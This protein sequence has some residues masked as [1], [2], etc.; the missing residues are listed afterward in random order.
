MRDFASRESRAASLSPAAKLLYSAFAGF[1]LLGLVS[2]A[3]LYGGIVGFGAR[4]TPELLYRRLVAH[5]TGGATDGAVAPLGERALLELT[6]AHLFSMSVLLLVAGH[7]FLLT[8]ASLR[9]KQWLIGIGIA[10]VAVH[11]AAPWLIRWLG[12]RAAS[13]LVYPVSGAFLI[14]SLGVMTIVPVWQMWRSRQ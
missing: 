11:L 3:Q 12:G 8:S 4:D 6:H 14:L 5:Y 9:V 1:N 13:G 7:L 2:S 10:A